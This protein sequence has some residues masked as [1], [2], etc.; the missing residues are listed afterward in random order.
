M[1]R[2]LLIACICLLPFKLPN[3]LLKV[4][5]IRI[6]MKAKIGF[7]IILTPKLIMNEH[8]KIGHFNIVKCNDISMETASYIGHFNII[9]GPFSIYFKK[10]G[11]IGNNN[12]VVRAPLGVTYGT[13]TLTLGE[14]T[15][16]T[17]GHYID[18]TRNIVFGDFSTL[19]GINSQIWTHGYVHEKEG[20]GRI[21]VDGETHIGNNVYIGSGC[22]FNPGITIKDGISVGSGSVLSKNLTESG[23][24]VNQPLRYFEHDVSIVKKKLIKLD[25]DEVVDDVYLKE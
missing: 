2:K 4:L 5:G 23:M 16:I 24:Y 18:L 13:S 10:R 1:I 15:K 8:C 3:I 20:A 19:A 21:R 7:S 11:A 6:S 17:S 12:K 14:L 9:K 22:L 25:N